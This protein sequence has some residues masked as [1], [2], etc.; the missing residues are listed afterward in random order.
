MYH[1]HNLTQ[2]T[3]CDVWIKILFIF[4]RGILLFS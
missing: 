1:I 3:R 2:S 4:F